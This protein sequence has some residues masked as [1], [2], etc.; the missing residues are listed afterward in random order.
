[1]KGI[2]NEDLYKLMSRIS[3]VEAAALTA[4]IEPNRVY[5]DD[6]LGNTFYI[7][8]SLNT[9]PHNANMVYQTTLNALIRAVQHSD[10][11]AF[12]AIENH[13]TG[14]YLSEELIEGG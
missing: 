11:E 9:D 10:L 4:G 14:T 6:H 3:I 7:Y 13:S 8:Q 12:I 5:A 2:S 1:M